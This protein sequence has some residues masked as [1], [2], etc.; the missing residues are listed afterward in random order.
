M[1]TIEVI[2]GGIIFLMLVYYCY[3]SR[4]EIRVL[5]D[6]IITLG[7]STTDVLEAL[8]HAGDQKE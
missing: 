4:K 1:V 5:K 7:K 2:L 3:L 8:S 6:Y